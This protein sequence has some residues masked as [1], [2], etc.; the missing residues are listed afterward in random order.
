MNLREK[1]C[2]AYT[3]TGQLWK[4]RERESRY[5]ET[6]CRHIYEWMR[7]DPQNGE[8]DL[9]KLH[10]DGDE[11]EEE[12]DIK[13]WRRFEDGST[14][15]EQDLPKL[16]SKGDEEEKEVNMKADLRTDPQRG[17]RT[18]RSS[19]VKMMKKKRRWIWGSWKHI[20]GRIHKGD[21]GLTKAQ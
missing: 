11:E 19:I 9:L 10:S 12:V 1:F 8:Q 17:S 21:A 18:Y 20:W 15:G 16:N 5:E 3:K 2:R 4:K 14:K 7:T 6:A 13:C